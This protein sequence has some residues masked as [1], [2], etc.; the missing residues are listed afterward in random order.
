MLGTNETMADGESYMFK[1]R[2]EGGIIE[3]RYEK[4]N[5][6]DQRLMITWPSQCLGKDKLKIYTTGPS[7]QG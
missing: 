2:K 1:R 5:V 4:I 6:S 7:M 3:L